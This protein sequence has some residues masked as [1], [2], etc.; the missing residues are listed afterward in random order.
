MSSAPN[1]V[2]CLLPCLRIPSVP[3]PVFGD[4]ECTTLTGGAHTKYNSIAFNGGSTADASPPSRRTNKPLG[5]GGLYSALQNIP[6]AP[7]V[8]AYVLLA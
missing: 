5:G 3:F 8:R 7:H 1:Q 4:F 2:K 6:H